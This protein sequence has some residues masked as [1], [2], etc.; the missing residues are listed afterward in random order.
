VGR[1]VATITASPPGSPRKLTAIED[2]EDRH[3]IIADGVGD[4][5]TA[6]SDRSQ[7]WADVVARHVAI[8]KPVQRLA[9]LDDGVGKA[10]GEAGRA[11]VVM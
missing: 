5:H 7:A 11:L 1:S 4:K 3:D 2:A 6:E 9:A 10:L 8:R